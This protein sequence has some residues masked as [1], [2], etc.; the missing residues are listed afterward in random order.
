[1]DNEKTDINWATY[2]FKQEVVNAIN[3]SGLPG[4][5]V[6]EVL[7]G[8]TLQVQNQILSEMKK[9]NEAV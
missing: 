8:L 4:V 3:T 9:D 6:Y 1:M 5:L 2:N 7:N